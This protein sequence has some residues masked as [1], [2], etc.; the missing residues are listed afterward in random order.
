MA[1]PGN[2]DTET[3]KGQY[4]NLD[5]SPATGTVT[6]SPQLASGTFLTDTSALVAV[7]PVNLVVA[8]DNTGSFTTLLPA[9]NDSDLSP[10]GWTYKVTEQF[11][12]NTRS[13]TIVVGV[14]TG[15]IDLVTVAPAVSSTSSVTMVK[16]VN[17]I[18]PDTNGN[19]AVTGA[20]GQQVWGVGPTSYPFTPIGSGSAYLIVDKTGSGN[21]GSIVFRDTG[22]ALAEVGNAA[23][24]D[25]HIKASATGTSF[26][27]AVIVKTASPNTGLVYVPQGLGVGTVPAEPLHVAQNLPAARTTTKIENTNATG[28]GSQGSQFQLAG[29]TI[30]W[31]AGTD[32]G[33]NGGNNFFVV[34]ANGAYMTGFIVNAAGQIG[35][36]TDSPGSALDVNGDLTVRS[37]VSGFASLRDRGRATVA[38]APASGTWVA[39]DTFLDSVGTR[40]LCTSSGTPGSWAGSAGDVNALKAASMGLVGMTEDLGMVPSQSAVTTGRLFVYPFVAGLSATVESVILAYQSATSGNTN[41]NTFVGIYN[42]AGTTLLGQTADLNSQ[43]SVTGGFRVIG[44]MATPFA[45]TAGVSYNAV[46]LNNYSSTGPQWMC[47]RLYGTN[48]GSGTGIINRVLVSSGTMTSLPSTLT[49]LSLAASGTNSRVAMG[50]GQGT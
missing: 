12:I 38:G 3:V 15:P 16:T 18:T 2:Y 4:I 11:G 46:L 34:N 26:V 1:L 9:T 19:I 13:Y 45:L 49:S 6:F 33:L 43:L 29:H 40:W 37:T 50:F 39:G 25:F 28:T 10:S 47:T 48:W 23:D 31:A 30:S 7:L 35:I 36:L 22:T 20:Y 27:D 14:G 8:L 21:D 41:T 5:G 32:V 17:G 42:S 44:D 24:D